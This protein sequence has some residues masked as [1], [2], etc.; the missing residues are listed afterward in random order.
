MSKV[1]QKQRNNIPLVV[2]HRG[3][4]YDAPENTIASFLLAWEQG[5]D[6]IEGD[7]HLTKD[8]HI[9]CI[10]D[11]DTNRVC[12]TNLVIKDSTL[13]ELKKLDIG[14]HFGAQFSDQRIPTIGQIFDT[15]PIGKKV[16]VEVK[17]GK[18]LLPILIHQIKLS[19]IDLSQIIVI[20]FDKY[21]IKEC[22]VI[23]P[24]LVSLWLNDF[25]EDFDIELITSTLIDIKAD[26]ISSNNTATEKLPST[27]IAL[28]KSYHSGWSIDNLDGIDKLINWGTQSIT[29]NNPGRVKVHLISDME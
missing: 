2:A 28:G 29:T 24:N 11:Y 15:V 21:V 27:V 9:V 20:S 19:N 8:E 10:H 5:A 3:A 6:A 22:K 23:E 25:D 4:S 17:C 1:F 13:E 18:E 14:S 7:F 26:G 12:E 16:L